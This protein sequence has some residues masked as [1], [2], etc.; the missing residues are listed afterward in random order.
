MYTSSILKDEEEKAAKKDDEVR[1]E[2]RREFNYK[3]V[4]YI[5]T[6]TSFCLLLAFFKVSF[7]N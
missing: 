7:K 3:E 5:L 4:K 6:L 2:R 1:Q